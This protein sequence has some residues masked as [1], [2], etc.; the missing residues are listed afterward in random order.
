[1]WREN[2]DRIALPRD[3]GGNDLSTDWS[4]YADRVR[5]TGPGGGDKPGFLKIRDSSGAYTY[6][7]AD[8]PTPAEMGAPSYYDV[9]SEGYYKFPLDFGGDSGTNTGTLIMHFGDLGT[10]IV[11][12][13]IKGTHSGTRYTATGI[14]TFHVG[15]IAE[16]AVR[17][18]KPRQ[19]FAQGQRA[20]TIEAVNNGPDTAPAVQV[21]TGLDPDSYVFHYPADMDFDPVTGVWDIGELAHNRTP[22]ELTIVVNGSSAREVL[23]AA[24][25]NTEA[26]SV[27]IDS[28]GDDVIPKPFSQADCEATSGNSWH[29]TDFLDYIKENDQAVIG[30]QTG[31]GEDSP[32]SLIA[33]E[34]PNVPFV[35]LQ[36]DPVR[37]LNR[38]EVDHYE[39]IGFRPKL[40]EPCRRPAFEAEA[41]ATVRDER[42]VGRGRENGG[43]RCHSVR[44]VNY[45]GQKG[46]WWPIASTGGDSTD[47]RVGQP[48][49]IVLSESRVTVAENGHGNSYT[50]K[51]NR[52]PVSPMSVL[53]DVD[54]LT[55][56]TVSRSQLLFGPGNWD[57]PQTV[58]VTGVDDDVDNPGGRR[59]TTIRHT[60]RG[61]G[62]GRADEQR[63]AVT[64]TDDGDAAGL[65]ISPTTLLVAGGGGSGGYSVRL[66]SQPA[67]DVRVTVASSDDQKATVNTG[68]RVV[69]GDQVW[70]VLSFNSVNWRHPQTVAVSF[71][72]DSGQA[73]ITNSASSGDPN[74]DGISSGVF[75]EAIPAAHKPAVSV[76]AGSCVVSGER[77]TFTLLTGRPVSK[78]LRV[79]YT[80]GRNWRAVPEDA[81]GSGTTTIAEGADQVEIVVPTQQL[82][83]ADT[84]LAP[85]GDTRKRD[86]GVPGTA[87]VVL[88]SSPEYDI[89]GESIAHVL[90]YHTDESRYC[91]R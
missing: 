54:D 91:Q 85:P 40:G 58:T 52:R 5:V 14:Y 4:A 16:L 25:R 27:C 44:A 63:V 35:L 31:T 30:A 76:V 62:F 79:D 88:A 89:A 65:V 75:V 1:L 46:H 69:S 55:A 51:L 29:A 19:G 72:A 11:E 43:R 78:G 23:T 38:L 86:S 41:T 80:I 56:A 49:G 3:G 45:A 81:L 2:I 50:V 34:F 87:T 20:F 48:P 74:Y 53:L 15:P 66:K 33:H 32:G 24:I 21:V 39:I 22:E 67:A 28:G 18:G 90:V 42:Y 59:Q 70:S 26:Y 36:W 68:T 6:A 57:I 7:S 37:L 64:V 12:R 77:A 60:A 8:P 71:H 84:P 83:D 9:D 47:Q 10:Y 61:G 82:P 17:E 13:S 73:V